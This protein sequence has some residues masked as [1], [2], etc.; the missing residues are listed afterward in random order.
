MEYKGYTIEDVSWVN[1]SESIRQD[2]D[3]S[4]EL[5]R[6][7]LRK[8]IFLIDEKDKELTSLE[9]EH[10]IPTIEFYG[11]GYEYNP[12]GAD[13]EPESYISL[14]WKRRETSEEAFKRIE[15]R[16]KEIEKEIKNN[17]AKENAR[18]QAEKIEAD[19]MIRHLRS[20]GYEVI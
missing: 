17:I 10:T 20:L 16:K 12:N 4:I 6:E 18:K 8:Y 11:Q 7:E 5:T 9:I 3:N 14:N 1:Q 2:D 15:K 19:R 13:Q